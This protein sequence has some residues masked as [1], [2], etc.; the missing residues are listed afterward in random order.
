MQD[1]SRDRTN[2]GKMEHQSTVIH[3]KSNKIDQ[4]LR[5]K[6]LIQ[7][8]VYR[9]RVQRKSVLQLAIQQAVATMY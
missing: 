4:T 5:E 1:T 8:N 3:K 6:G 9:V 2:F 7:V